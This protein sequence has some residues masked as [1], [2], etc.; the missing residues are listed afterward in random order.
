MESTK[1]SGMNDF[2]TVEASHSGL[3]IQ[4]QTIE[5]TISFLRYG[6]FDVDQMPGASDR[7]A[8]HITTITKTA[9]DKPYS[10]ASE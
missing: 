1:L 6:K 4:K 7:T 10:Q 2:T 9:I 3:L 5:Q 8:P